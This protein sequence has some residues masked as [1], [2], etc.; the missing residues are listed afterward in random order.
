[1]ARWKVPR[2]SGHSFTKGSFRAY[3]RQCG[4]FSQPVEISYQRFFEGDASRMWR[5][6]SAETCAVVIVPG[7]ERAPN[8]ADGKTL[9]NETLA[10]LAVGDL[11]CEER[12]YESPIR[13]E[14]VGELRHAEK[15]LV[16][17]IL[18]WPEFFEV[19]LTGY[20]PDGYTLPVSSPSISPHL[21][22]EW[23]SLDLMER[24]LTDTE[25]EA[26]QAAVEELAA[27]AASDV[28]ALCWSELPPIQ[29]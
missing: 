25:E 22:Y 24:L 2:P 23:G 10:R 1:M 18:K 26:R 21:G 6:A 27:L 17:H 11:V 19:R 16:A 4:H 9:A 28:P 5:R 7:A 20:L 14:K 12:P 3:V 13:A 15:M 8:L 29:P